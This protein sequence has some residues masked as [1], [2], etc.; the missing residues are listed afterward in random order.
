[1]VRRLERCRPSGSENRERSGECED[2]LGHS[3]PL[4]LEWSGA[5]DPGSKGQ[6]GSD[7]EP[8]TPRMAR[9]TPP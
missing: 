7:F 3:E 6:D 8:L 4:G 9:Y 5:D 1:M 2:E